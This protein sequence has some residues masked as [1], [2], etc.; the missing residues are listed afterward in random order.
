MDG[1]PLSLD[2]LWAGVEA[3]Q[4]QALPFLSTMGS[5]VWLDTSPELL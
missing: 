5:L 2:F 1:P 4:T 3:L